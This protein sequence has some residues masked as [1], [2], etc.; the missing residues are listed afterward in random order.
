MNEGAF[1]ADAALEAS[2]AVPRSLHIGIVA[3][4]AG[5][6]LGAGSYGFIA[7]LAFIALAWFF[8]GDPT[9]CTVKRSSS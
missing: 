8:I 9:A 4:S 7:I 6:A 5:E 1:V 3:C 2:G